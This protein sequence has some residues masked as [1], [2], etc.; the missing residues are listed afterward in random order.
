MH[1]ACQNNV[2]GKLALFFNTFE[3]NSSETCP[4]ENLNG[5][6]R[7]KSHGVIYSKPFRFRIPELITKKEL[8]KAFILQSIIRASLHFAE[9]TFVFVHRPPSK[10]IL[11]S[12]ICNIVDFMRYVSDK[13]C[14]RNSAKK[15]THEISRLKVHQ[16][17][18]AQ[19]V[20]DFE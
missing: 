17:S 2:G 5:K 3:H 13:T 12:C 9:V 1:Q 10:D 11:R 8:Y 6:P 16:I 4:H 15:G 7:A 18:P 19:N 14:I 20:A